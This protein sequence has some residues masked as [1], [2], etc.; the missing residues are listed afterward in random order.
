MGD[1]QAL[2]LPRVSREAIIEALRQEAGLG[3]DQVTHVTATTTL[4]R[5]IQDGGAAALPVAT[6]LDLVTLPG[7]PDGLD[8]SLDAFPEPDA[9][10]RSK[11]AYRAQVREWQQ[12]ASGRRLRTGIQVDDSL[13]RFVRE[14]AQGRVG[15][16]LLASRRQYAT[17][18][19]AL[20]AAGVR[21][22]R[23]VAQDPPGQLAARA[24]TQA[25]VDVP[26][27]GAPRDLLWVDLDDLAAGT[28][29]EA[30]DLTRRIGSALRKAYGDAPRRTVVHHGFYFYSPVQWALFQA[31][32]RV[33]GVDQVF[34]VHDDGENPAFSTWRYFFR[35]E[36]QMPVPRPVHV[37]HDLT[38]AASAF[39]DVLTGV[40]AGTPTGVEV[41]ECRSP[42]ELVRLW[43]AE[44]AGDKPAPARFAASAEQVERYVGRLGRQ[45]ARDEGDDEPPAPT[46]SQLPVGSFLLALHGCITGEDDWWFLLHA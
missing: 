10:V 35:S 12:E 9:L 15:R 39:R 37:A 45:V 21:P 19:H 1:M 6:L 22:Q 34:I 33:P 42:A 23:L 30:R 2:A 13:R 16:A 7:L 32:A 36:W 24:W 29:P 41:V 44:T 4:A 38:P 25:E 8:L 11:M 28:T 31:L 40:G 17:T 26:A 20:V 5:A 43:R 14:N 46:L 18:V 27:L 3:W